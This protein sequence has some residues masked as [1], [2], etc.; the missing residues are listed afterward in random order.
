M[1][2]HLNA[3]GGESAVGFTENTGEVGGRACA[4]AG[5][6]CAPVPTVIQTLRGEA[7]VHVGQ[8]RLD[9]VGAWVWWNPQVADVQPRFHV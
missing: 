1:R 6:A 3:C 8:L 7:A 9:G 2:Y 5:R 4:R